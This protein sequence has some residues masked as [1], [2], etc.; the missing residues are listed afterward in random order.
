MTTSTRQSNT[1]VTTRTP[2]MLARW[3]LAP[4]VGL[5]TLSTKGGQK[6][7][8]IAKFVSRFS[9]LSR[10]QAEEAIAE[11]TVT[12]DGHVVATPAQK[13]DPEAANVRV[14]GK[15]VRAEQASRPRLFLVHKLAGELVTRTDPQGRPTLFERLEAMSLPRGLKAVG[16]LDMPSEGLILLTDDGEFSRYLELPSSRIKRTYRVRAFGTVTASKLRTLRR[17]VELPDGQRLRGMHVA[18][19]ATS[20][21]TP[22]GEELHPRGNVWLRIEL[23]EGKNREIRRALEAMSL[24]VGRL[25]RIEYGPFRLQGLPRGAAVQVK[26]PEAMLQHFHVGTKRRGAEDAV[27]PERS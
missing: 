5:R 2:T 20:A 4:R 12:L 14:R 15:R 24:H 9:E 3:T 21:A 13:V 25:V 8:R 22:E 17:G 27:E 16:R 26:V 23:S 1:I 11:G 19:E 10:R 6:E 18:L 7:W